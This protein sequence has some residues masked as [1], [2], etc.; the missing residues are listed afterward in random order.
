MKK[1]PMNLNC[2]CEECKFAKPMFCSDGS[3]DDVCDES[4]ITDFLA[5]MSID[6]H[7]ELAGATGREERS[8]I[9]KK[10]EK[11]EELCSAIG[12]FFTICGKD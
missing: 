7:E 4:K 8:V 5:E 2:D 6:L 10:I 11:S 9:M 1:C 3:I 12:H